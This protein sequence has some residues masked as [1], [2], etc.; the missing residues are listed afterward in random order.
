MHNV[1]AL[2]YAYTVSDSCL[3]WPDMHGKAIYVRLVLMPI[4]IG[5]AI[6][7]RGGH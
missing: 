4:L 2:I 3:A 6:T 5:V 1:S 7:S